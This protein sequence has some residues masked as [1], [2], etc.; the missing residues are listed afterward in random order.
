[1]Q[2]KLTNNLFL[3]IDLAM[4]TIY[5]LYL[6]YQGAFL[7]DTPIFQMYDYNKPL[8]QMLFCFNA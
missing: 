4:T 1:M 2:N 8:E 3:S 5:M 6:H 7:S